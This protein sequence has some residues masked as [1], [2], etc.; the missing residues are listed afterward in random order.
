MLSKKYL[1]ELKNEYLKNKENDI[2]ER[3]FKKVE[4]INL[5]SD[6]NINLDTKFNYEIITHGI[7]NQSNSGRCWIFGGLNILREEIIKKCNLDNFELSESYIS[8]YDKLEKINY[9]IEKIIE[10]IDKGKD[11]YDEYLS[12]LL[13]TG[14]EDGGYYSTFVSLVKKYGIVPKNIY[15]E[16]YQSSNTSEINQILNRLIK[17][18]YLE[19]KNSS[20]REKVKEKYIKYA[21]RIISNTYGKIISTFNFEYIDK[22]NN[23]HVEKKLTPKDFYNKY[24]KK[25]FLDDYIEV[26]CFED[27][28]YKINNLYEIEGTSN[29]VGVKDINVLN[30]S[31]FDMKRL[32]LKQIKN[33]EPVYFSASTPVKYL[34]GI[35]IDVFKRYGDIFDIDLELNNN[36][37]IKTNDKTGEHV[38][39][40]TGVNVVDGKTKMWKIENSWGETEGDSGYFIAT[41]DW[42]N[43]Y[44]FNIIINKKYLTK[45]QK[46]IL[47]NRPIK[48]KSINSKF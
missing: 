4:L 5:I 2:K 25:D 6:N 16:T 22:N 1:I 31:I 39:V 7:T 48:I 47:K 30:I 27:E 41:D 44:V 15:P 42:V 46:M 18:F 10:L 36:E 29:I 12:C 26:F 20:K 17:K 8:F 37:I 38:M 33:N 24:I 34:D 21:Y 45:K 28:K 40:F 13:S 35:W 23:Y 19:I 11:E 32:L 9:A 43:K 3:M 14:I